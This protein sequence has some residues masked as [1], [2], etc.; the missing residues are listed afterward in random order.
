MT[1]RFQFDEQIF[2]LF[3]CEKCEKCDKAQYS[4]EKCM[5]GVIMD[6]YAGGIFDNLHKIVRETRIVKPVKNILDWQYVIKKHKLC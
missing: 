4:G 2:K 5:D 1:L 3:S 6:V